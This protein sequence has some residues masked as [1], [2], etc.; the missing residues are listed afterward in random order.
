M[1][2]LADKRSIFRRLDFLP[3]WAAVALG[4]GLGGVAG[5][6]LLQAHPVAGV[7]AFVALLA[8]AGALALSGEPVAIFEAAEVEEPAE[9]EGPQVV[10]PGWVALPG[11]TFLM[12]SPEDEEGRFDREGP[13]HE[14]RLSPFEIMQYPVTRQ[15]YA[16]VMGKDP[17]SPAGEAD[18]RPVNN[19]SWLD[20]VEF[21]NRLSVEEGLAECYRIRDE[22]VS[23]DR[24]AGGYRLPTEAEW[25]YACRAGTRTRWSFGDDEADLGRHAWYGANSGNEAHPVGEKEANPWHIHDL[26]GNVYEWCWDWFEEPYPEDPQQDPTGPDDGSFRVL[27]GGA[28]FNSS[29]FLRS[30][31]RGRVRPGIRGREFGFRCVRSPRRQP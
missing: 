19:V 21:C 28:F 14:V 16:E 25:E 13:A 30:A 12:G 3:A 4:V 2:E 29:R 20:A 8:L 9:P 15:A 22:E 5:G 6:L 11:G 31:G 18:R 24:S 10:R 7:A 1:P 23:W 26:H 17:G 27:R